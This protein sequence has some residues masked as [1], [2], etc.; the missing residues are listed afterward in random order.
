M[1]QSRPSLDIPSGKF[2]VRADSKDP[3]LDSILLQVDWEPVFHKVSC[4]RDLV[5]EVVAAPFAAQKF[6][7]LQTVVQKRAMFA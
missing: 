3:V 5:G 1:Y 2:S 7:V 4:V 6:L